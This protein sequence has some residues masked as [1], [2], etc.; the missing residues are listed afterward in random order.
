MSAFYLAQLLFGLHD[1][2]PH[3]NQQTMFLIGEH[4]AGT[5]D[6][7]EVPAR[8]GY[9]TAAGLMGGTRWNG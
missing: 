8:L 3:D 2:I 7:A 1:R 4:S 6:H 9:T 5:E